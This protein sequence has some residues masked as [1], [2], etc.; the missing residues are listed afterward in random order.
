MRTDNERSFDID[1][2]YVKSAESGAVKSAVMGGEV[3]Y[4]AWVLDTLIF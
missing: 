4:W 1:G 3:G 2:V